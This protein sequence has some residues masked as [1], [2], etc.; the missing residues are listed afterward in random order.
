M[1]RC[2]PS[3]PVLLQSEG[4]SPNGQTP[5]GARLRP[6]GWCCAPSF[7]L[8][9]EGPESVHIPPA[10]DTGVMASRALG[11]MSQVCG[12]HISQWE[13]VLGPARVCGVHTSH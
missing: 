5:L 10:T 9:L 7:L 4:V 2:P 13:G 8:P 12:V 1:G 6:A 3:P 11:L